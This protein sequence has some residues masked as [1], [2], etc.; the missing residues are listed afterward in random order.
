MRPRPLKASPVR[1]L[2][3]A[4]LG[5]VAAE[6][7]T[8]L[9]VLIYAYEADGPSAVG[10]VAVLQLLPAVV[11][12]PLAPAVI[13]RLE[14]PT[15]LVLAYVLQAAA[16]VLTALAALVGPSWAVYIGAAL[17]T[18]SLTLTRPAHAAALVAIARTPEEL[19]AANGAGG[20]VDGAGIVLG[21]LA[22][23][24]LYTTAGPSG[25]LLA[26]AG[27]LCVSAGLAASVRVERWQRAT[28]RTTTVQALR[29]A[30]QVITDRSGPAAA[31][32]ALVAVWISAGLLDVLVVVLALGELRGGSELAGGLNAALGVGAMIAGAVATRLAGGRSVASIGVGLAIAAVAIGAVAVTRGPVV[33]LVLFAF[34]G[35]GYSFAEIGS[36]S[37]LLRLAP[38]RSVGPVFGLVEGIYAAALAVGA[39]LGPL[40]LI[41]APASA[42]LVAIAVGLALTALGLA[43]A[44]AGVARAI[45]VPPAEL[46]LLRAVPLFAPLPVPTVEW[47]AR[48]AM[49]IEVPAGRPIVREGEPGDRFYAIGRGRAGVTRQGRDVGTLIAGDS[50]GE[51]ALLR[52]SPRTATVTALED[53]WLVSLR[54]DAFLS[55]VTDHTI[56]AST[57]EATVEA[58]LRRDAARDTQVGSDRPEAP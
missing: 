40:L 38:A 18:T 6:W 16:V 57:A 11:V 4:Y 33:A 34:A 39:A 21:P 23:A 5:F 8:W 19:T 26:T 24:A 13:A 55:A 25:F 22:V 28:A 2:L 35:A 31:T 46:A 48:G 3:A 58:R 20:A 7:G 54:R 29:E 47:L 17:I 41:A 50:F 52:G 32:A 49:R 45:R 42:G 43:P 10:A 44:L 53:A 12:A 27:V 36:R 37:T 15:P 14:R 30:V 56:A 51:I 9:A 1:R